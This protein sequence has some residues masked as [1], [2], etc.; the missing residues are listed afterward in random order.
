MKAADAEAEEGTSSREQGA[1]SENAILFK[2]SCT[3]CPR[4][5]LEGFLGYMQIF[6]TFSETSGTFILQLN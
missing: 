5:G 3:S 2:N 1:T 4:N 6:E